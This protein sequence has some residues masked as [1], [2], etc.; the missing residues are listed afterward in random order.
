MLDPIQYEFLFLFTTLTD[1]ESGAGAE[2]S[3]FWLQ[4][5][6]A[7]ALQHCLPVS[8]TPTMTMTKLSNDLAVSMVVIEPI[9]Y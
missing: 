3:I 5:L 1:P 4:L 8:T 9:R 6:V 7:P 2:T